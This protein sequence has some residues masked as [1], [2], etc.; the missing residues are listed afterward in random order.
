MTVKELIKELQRRNQDL[1]VRIE[2][3][4]WAQPIKMVERAVYYS[5]GKHYCIDPDD[6]DGLTEERVIL[7][8]KHQ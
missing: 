4:Q 7:L 6:E 5:D 8:I 2:D 3:N 1:E